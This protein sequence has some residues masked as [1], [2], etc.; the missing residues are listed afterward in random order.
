MSANSGLTLNNILAL[1]LKSCSMKNFVVKLM[2]E[3]FNE[4]ELENKTIKRYPFSRR[5][6]GGS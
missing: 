5:W 1:K 2:R 4:E 6:E 3:L